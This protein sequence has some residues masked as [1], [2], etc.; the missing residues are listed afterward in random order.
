MGDG[1]TCMQYLEKILLYRN[2]RRGGKQAIH[3][4]LERAL[5]RYLS[6]SNTLTIRTTLAFSAFSD[7]VWCPLYFNVP[8]FPR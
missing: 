5:F 1:A 2:Q 6:F 7:T 4:L 8:I 3:I